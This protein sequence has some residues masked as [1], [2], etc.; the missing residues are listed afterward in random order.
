MRGEFRKRCDL[1][2]DIDGEGGG[3]WPLL[4]THHPMPSIV[5]CVDHL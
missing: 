2:V 4:L 5:V 1:A 3:W